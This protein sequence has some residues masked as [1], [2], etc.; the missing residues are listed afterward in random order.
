M[1]GGLLGAT[2]TTLF[3]VPI[4]YSY[5]RTK[6]PVDQERRL[7]EEERTEALESEWDLLERASVKYSDPHQAGSETE[8]QL[9]QQRGRAEAAASRAEGRRHGPPA[10]ALAAVRASRFPRCCWDCWCCS[11]A[12]FSPATF[13]FRAARRWFARK[14]RSTE[15]TCR[16]WR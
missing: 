14:P 15:R 6:P 16:A 3:V 4:I 2:V 5:L 12:H 11:S 10:E 8:Q 13:R 1:I 9:R 7:E